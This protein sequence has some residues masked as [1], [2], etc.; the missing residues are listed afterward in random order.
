MS[1]QTSTKLF[2]VQDAE[3]PM[4]VVAVDWKAALDAWRRQVSI[5]DDLAAGYPAE[6][7]EPDGIMLVCGS[8]ELL[9]CEPALIE[10]CGAAVEDVGT[11]P[12]NHGP[13]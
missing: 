7:L 3:C 6:V 9:I 1:I 8:D 4:Y 11:H 10:G 12:F 5:E 13:D 2:H